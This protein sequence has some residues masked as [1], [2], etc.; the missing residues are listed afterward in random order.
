MDKEEL[1]QVDAEES[2]PVRR[3]KETLAMGLGAAILLGCLS[4]YLW[5]IE[6]ELW[7]VLVALLALAMILVGFTLSWKANC[8]VCQSPLNG[9][10]SGVCGP[11]GNCMHYLKM[12][13]KRIFPLE[14][15]YSSS[16]PMFAIPWESLE[17]I[18][19]RCCGCG[20]A[21][22]RVELIS[23][24][25]FRGLSLS[26]KMPHCE[27]CRKGAYIKQGDKVTTDSLTANPATYISVAVKS[28]RFYHEVMMMNHGAYS[29]LG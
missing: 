28:H 27:T 9:L 7:S 15:D 5:N 6:H 18:P 24:Q 21:A 12:E 1:K 11:C 2:T 25:A 22:V 16:I 19:Q 23:S 13:N 20:Q 3:V 8:P 26:A 14:E 10:S 4:L 29:I 17:G